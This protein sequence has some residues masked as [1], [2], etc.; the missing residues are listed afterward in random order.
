MSSD[1]S[2]KLSIMSF[3]CTNELSEMFEL[4]SLKC[5]IILTK[6]QNLGVCVWKR[7]L[8]VIIIFEFNV[9]DCVYKRELNPKTL[10]FPR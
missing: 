9:Q 1:F 10:F 3:L 8:P 4:I 5:L 6:A 2:I 7:V